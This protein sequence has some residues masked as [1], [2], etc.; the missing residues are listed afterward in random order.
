MAGIKK[1]KWKGGVR[2]PWYILFPG[3]FCALVAHFIAP[4]RGALYAFTNYKGI[5]SY[6]YIGFRNFIEIFS[7]KTEINAILNTFKIAIPFV[8]LTLLFGMLLALMLKSGI[9]SRHVLRSI[10][11]SPVV[12]IPMAVAQVWKF[13]FDYDG[14]LNLV[15]NR[16][17]MSEIT[18]N[19]LGNLDTSIWCVLFVLVWQNMGYSMVIFNAGLESIPE[20]L[21]EAASID[22]CAGWNRFRSITL[23]LLAPSF[24]VC[25]TMMTITGLRVFDQIMSL[26]GGGPVNMTHTLA[27]DFY[28]Q[29]WNKSRYGYGSALALILTLLVSVVGILQVTVL[30][31]REEMMR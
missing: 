16:I 8:G 29:T 10:Y 6:K 27:S 26:T 18:T 3:L 4:I 24:T 25:V 11:F 5:G 23:P 7:S 17:G 19:W 9:K 22:G 12:M 21:Y 30:Q 15:L 20:E 28:Y 14:P 13:I 1:K 31:K 2:V